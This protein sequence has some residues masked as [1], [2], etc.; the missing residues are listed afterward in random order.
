[1]EGNPGPVSGQVGQF[2]PHAL[3]GPQHEPPS[4][5]EGAGGA[6]VGSVVSSGQMPDALAH[7]LSAAEAASE[8]GKS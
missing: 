6:R 7:L 8:E 2:P 1:M 5:F 4:N 3:Y